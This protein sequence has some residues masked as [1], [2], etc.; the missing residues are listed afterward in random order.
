MELTEIEQTL[1][2]AVLHVRKEGLTVETRLF[3]SGIEV[4]D[5]GVAYANGEG[6]VCL[7]GAV[8]LAHPDQGSNE[9]FMNRASEILCISLGAASALERGFERGDGEPLAAGLDVGEGPFY[10]LGQK[11]NGWLG[12]LPKLLEQLDSAEVKLKAAI[13]AQVAAREDPNE[14]WVPTARYGQTFSPPEYRRKLTALA[15]KEVEE[16]QALIGVKA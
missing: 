1:K 12:D 14:K 15:R 2:A 6:I 11:L 4:D 3:H 10:N 7:L 16:L 5:E 9:Y 13:A 8:C